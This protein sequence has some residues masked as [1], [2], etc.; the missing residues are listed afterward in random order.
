MA[1]GRDPNHQNDTEDRTWRSKTRPNYFAEGVEEVFS[2]H[3]TQLVS[4]TK[5]LATETRANVPLFV[6]F[7][8]VTDVKSG[9]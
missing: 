6:W 5:C 2:V 9:H 7:S 3:K 4:H 1:P 8:K